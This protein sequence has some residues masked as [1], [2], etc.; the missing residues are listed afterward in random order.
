MLKRSS[1]AYSWYIASLLAV[2]AAINYADRSAIS[3][4]LP[5]IGTDLGMSDV[6]LGALGSAFLWTY[7]ICSPVSGYLADRLPRGRVIVWTLVAW[8]LV[9]L[10][11]AWVKTPWQMIGAR[12]LLGITECAFVPTAIA[13]AAEYH[14][15][16]T[17][18]RA[19]GLQLAGYNLGVVLG[20][21]FAGYS[22]DRWGWRPAFHVLGTVGLVMALVVKLTVPQTRTGAAF[23]RETPHVSPLQAARRIFSI[24]SYVIVLLESSCVAAGVWMFFAWLPLYFR[25]TFDLSLTAAGLAGTFGLQAAATAASLLAG[26]ASDKFSGQHRE[27]RMLFQFLCFVAAIPFLAVFAGKSSLETVSLAILLFAFFR[28]LGSSNDTVIECDVLPSGCWSTALGVT[29]ASNCI[30]G[31]IGVLLAGYLKADFGLAGVFGGQA[32]TVA[33]AAGLVCFGY[34]RFLRRDVAAAEAE[35][36]AR[37]VYES[38]STEPVF[39][40]SSIARQTATEARPS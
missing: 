11:T 34:R 24:P 13:L 6:M 19:I 20:G 2:V 26:Y 7:A 35:R 27:R 3:S 5:L 25:E 33:M 15:G 36:K 17:R 21:V 31:G 29:N 30:A 8:S 28:T 40:D 18:A 22:G 32:L 12:L 9:T 4:V 10:A 39:E 16:R 14:P 1:S 37:A 38:R 23:G